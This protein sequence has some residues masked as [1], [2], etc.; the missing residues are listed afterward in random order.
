[1]DNY[2]NLFQLPLTLPIDT[3]HLNR[4]YQ[5][6]QRQYHPDNFATANDNDKVAII[7][8]SATI[9]DG[10][11][12]L[13]NPVEAA[14]HLLALQGFDIMAENSTVHDTDFLMEQ[15]ELREQLDEIENQ[16]NHALLDDVFVDI[17]A[18]KQSVYT[19]LLVDIAEQNWQSSLNQIYKIRYLSKLIEH[20]EQLQEKNSAL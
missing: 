10:Y 5:Q 14:E 17:L 3:I 6:L 12:T 2:F 16:E 11:R 20:I 15:F 18:R 7:Q 1:M 4:E 13:K 9:N 19:N 8:K